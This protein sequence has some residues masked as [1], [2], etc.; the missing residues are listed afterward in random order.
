MSVRINKD[1]G[2]V[3]LYGIV[4]DAWGE[5]SFTSVDVIDALGKLGGKRALIRINSPGGV[6]DEG[7]AI[8]NAI[9]RYS[10]GSDT[11]VDALAAS[12]ASVIAL[13]GDRRTTSSGARWMIHRALTIDMGNAS[14]LRKT[15][16]TLE[17]YDKSIV[18]IYG[19]YL[20]DENGHMM[21]HDQIMQ[22]MEAETWYT[23]ESSVASGLATQ[24]GETTEAVPQVAAWFK[25]PPAA[26]FEQANRAKIAAIKAKAFR[27]RIA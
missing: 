14:Q 9:K 13:A 26:L 6:A 11:V 18:E 17:T 5:E 24:L 15:A 3:F 1:S 8:Y 20:K 7:I 27:S 4:G 25:N 19:K 22:L 12:A 21:Q 23:S 2:E 16:D 10:A